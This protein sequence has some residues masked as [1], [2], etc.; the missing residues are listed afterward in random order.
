[1]IA[2][3]KKLMEKQRKNPDKAVDQ[4]VLHNMLEKIGFIDRRMEPLDPLLYPSGKV[5]FD[6][7]LNTAMNIKLMIVHANY[8]VGSK[9]MVKL[10]S[11]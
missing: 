11:K 3:L 9:A 6:L 7:A 8:R 5:F 2:L 10:L 1:M 4:L